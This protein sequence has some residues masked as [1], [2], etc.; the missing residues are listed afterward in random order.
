[1][2]FKVA[3]FVIK[4]GLGIGLG[5]LILIWTGAAIV[6][7]IRSG[8]NP[9]DNMSFVIND[10]NKCEKYPV[11]TYIACPICEREFYKENSPFCSRKCEDKY[12]DMKRNYDTATQ[13]EKNL[14]SY[15]KN[16]K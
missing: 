13:A 10:V 4:I 2:I 16:Y 11:G 14:N 12:W 3:K 5:I 1:M 8:E 15:G 9:H 6:G 7:W